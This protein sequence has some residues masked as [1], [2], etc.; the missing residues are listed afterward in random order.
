MFLRCPSGLC[1][2]VHPLQRTTLARPPSLQSRS[3]SFLLR[4]PPCPPCYDF[5]P[6]PPRCGYLHRSSRCTACLGSPSRVDGPSGRC[7]RFDHRRT[8]SGGAGHRH[9]YCYHCRD[10]HPLLQDQDRPEAHVP[11]LS[12]CHPREARV[13]VVRGQSAAQAEDGTWRSGLQAVKER[14]ESGMA[15]SL[16]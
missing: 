2:G 14:R 16:S 12:D 11:R 9:H 4:L 7:W 5:P 15:C 3:S 1:H 10:G 6:H 13:R 8:E